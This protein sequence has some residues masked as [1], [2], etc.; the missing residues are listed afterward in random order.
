MRNP[1]RLRELGCLLG[2]DFTKSGREARLVE[3]GGMLDN[4]F[5][6]P[7]D[8]ADASHRLGDE[9]G[10]RALEEHSGQ[11][12]YDRVE[13]PSEVRCCRRFSKRGHF[14][15]RQTKVLVRRSE[16]G[17]AVRVAPAELVV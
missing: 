2:D 8:L 17:P 15:R 5:G 7:G 9:A 1:H 6:I 13:K 4:N 11:P 14:K 12:L 10:L 16:K 3:A